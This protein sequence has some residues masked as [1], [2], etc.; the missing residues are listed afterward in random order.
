M[1]KFVI[2][3]VNKNA[4]LPGLMAGRAPPVYHYTEQSIPTVYQLPYCIFALTTA[5]NDTST[6]ISCYIKRQV[7][8]ERH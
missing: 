5:K 4:D 3:Q 6:H 8:Q 7:E 2:L 1:N